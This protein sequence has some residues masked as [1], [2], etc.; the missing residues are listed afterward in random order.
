MIQSAC[1]ETGNRGDPAS[2]MDGDGVILAL[3]AGE[4]GEAEEECYT[5]AAL[6]TCVCCDF[7]YK[8]IACH[9]DVPFCI[10]PTPG[11]TV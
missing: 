2:G 3:R 9:P 1:I 10:R 6:N 8:S 4:T 11:P 7:T 5:D